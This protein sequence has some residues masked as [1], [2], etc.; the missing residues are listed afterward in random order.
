[1]RILLVE[2]EAPV[3]RAL[4]RWLTDWGHE[5]ETCCTFR[6][7]ALRL[8]KGDLDLLLTDLNLE[9]SPGPKTPDT[10]FGL[11]AFMMFPVPVIAISG[12]DLES[13]FM[14]AAARANKTR[15]AFVKKGDTAALRSALTRLSPAAFEEEALVLTRSADELRPACHQF[16]AQDFSAEDLALFESVAAS[17]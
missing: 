14:A 15:V 2:D 16:F 8:P 11:E 7:A 13:A 1:M 9:D 6:C 3:R 4:T 10:L 12:Y 17:G 5:V